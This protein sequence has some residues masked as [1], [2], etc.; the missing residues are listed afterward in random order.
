M[1]SATAGWHQVKEENM[2][3][4]SKQERRTQLDKQV[5]R[6]C[7]SMMPSMLVVLP[8]YHPVDCSSVSG[9]AC[10]SGIWW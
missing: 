4:L 5:G 10:V 3:L 8:L 6:L 9:C 7:D 2:Q 1:A